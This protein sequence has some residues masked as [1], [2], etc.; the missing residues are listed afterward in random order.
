MADSFG[1]ALASIALLYP[2][3]RTFDDLCK[4]FRETRAF[5][6]NLDREKRVLEI[7]M[8]RFQRYGTYKIHELAEEI[9]PNDAT[10]QNTARLKAF[11]DIMLSLFE[12]CNELMRKYEHGLNQLD[13]AGSFENSN[14]SLVPPTPSI[15][16]SEAPSR[17][18]TLSKRWMGKFRY[19]FMNKS[20]SAYGSRHCSYSPTSSVSNSS[21]EATSKP[22]P[23]PSS[24]PSG[25]GQQA[26]SEYSRATPRNSLWSPFLTKRRARTQDSIPDANKSSSISRVIT[27]QAEYHDDR[28]SDE[29]SEVN[30][31]RKHRQEAQV[32]QS[33][34]RFRSRMRWLREDREMLNTLIYELR[35][36]NDDLD[37]ILILRPLDDPLR[38][39]PTGV[40]GSHNSNIL[41]SDGHSSDDNNSNCHSSDVTKRV[42]KA[43]G[44]LHE[45][46]KTLNIEFEGQGP[47]YLS[48][49]LKEDNNDSRKDLTQAGVQLRNG[50]MVFNIQRHES[51][52]G[53]RPASLAV[54]TVDLVAKNKSGQPLK[55]RQLQSLNRPAD[56]QHQNSGTNVE[57]WGYFRTPN[58]PKNAHYLFHDK[59]WKWSSPQNLEEALISPS[60][61]ENITPYQIIILA[62]L[63]VLGYM[64]F[65]TVRETCGNPQI[66]HFRY[67]QTLE[68]IDPWGNDGGNGP[69]ILKPWLS[70]GFGRKPV[71]PKI[72]GGSGQTKSTN[73]SIVELGLILYQIGSRR[74]VEYGAGINGFEKAQSEAIRNRHLMEHIV[75]IPYA[76]IV[77]ACLTY[78]S[79]PSM[80]RH[81]ETDIEF[82]K[83]IS[84]N[85]FS[86]QQTLQGTTSAFGENP[87]ILTLQDPPKIITDPSKEIYLGVESTAWIGSENGGGSGGGSESGGGG[88]P[89]SIPPLTVDVN[90]NHSTLG[91]EPGL[92]PDFTSTTP[93]TTLF[94]INNNR[95]GKA[96]FANREGMMPPTKPP[97]RVA[98]EVDE[99]LLGF[100]GNPKVRF[101]GD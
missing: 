6:S 50:S 18:N 29:T 68:E 3:Y 78:K 31:L 33:N 59:F 87:T 71:P 62:R 46:F 60:F 83:A 64:Y 101:N 35:N 53:D 88:A 92:D 74:K 24:L 4:S 93:P 69:L 8:C 95:E 13:A 40:Q 36:G 55:D 81:Q 57:T 26:T 28:P 37:S 34:S 76:D 5:D 90:V 65:A 52:N 89:F 45:S 43:L 56:I 79:Q 100:G 67:F 75:G 11:C 7:Q 14:S 63:I 22:L 21:I 66:R 20:N 41:N 15:L 2:I 38:L 47:Y 94:N 98:G 25:Q 30:A 44:R 96:T 91:S 61:R 49:Q 58:H 27:S 10:H 23:S 77:N 1:I 84:L 54:E 85:L 17:S 39:L 19:L 80:T 51:P 48:V 82:M 99:T 42:Q 86:C 12:Q 97:P 70:F 73:A 72:G 32:I 16:V 9:D